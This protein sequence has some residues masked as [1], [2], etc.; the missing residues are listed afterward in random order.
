[1]N[2]NKKTYKLERQFSLLLISVVIF[3]QNKLTANEIDTITTLD[4]KTYSNVT[5]SKQTP[6]YL[7]IFHSKGVVTLDFKNLPDE[8]KKKF[9]YTEEGN[10]NYKKNCLAKYIKY[11]K[12]KLNICSKKLNNKLEELKEIEN[13]HNRKT[14]SF[15]KLL[16]RINR[17]SDST[18]I[19]TDTRTIDSSGQTTEIN[20]NA[21]I[22][23]NGR[24]SGGYY[25][26][27]LQ[28]IQLEMQ[29]QKQQNI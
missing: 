11:N 21:D 5:I 17:I 20:N 29:H 8:V 7:S 27:I 26:S 4:G 28:V 14:V 3:F 2:I 15:N 6:S 9:N 22:S 23:I 12:R 25:D 10:L 13:I 18:I 19:T 16:E 24:S 1:M